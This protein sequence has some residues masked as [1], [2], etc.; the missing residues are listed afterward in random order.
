VVEKK[1]PSQN[2]EFKRVVCK[3]L[4]P[5]DLSGMASMP[6][7]TILPGPPSPTPSQNLEN[8]ETEK[9]NK[10]VD[11]HV[12]EMGHYKGGENANDTE[13][14]WDYDGSEGRISIC[15][16]AIEKIGASR[17]ESS[18]HHLPESKGFASG[19]WRLHQKQLGCFAGDLRVSPPS[20]CLHSQVG[21]SRI[22]L[23]CEA[24]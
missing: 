13:S 17:E 2:I 24:L 18:F 19:E 3:I 1:F 7:Q 10:T 15:L 21:L 16:T 6:V 20:D 9:G 11:A 14:E 23:H 12:S 8:K 4:H 22:S 5:N